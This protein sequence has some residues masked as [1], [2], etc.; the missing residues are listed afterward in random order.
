VLRDFWGVQQRGFSA[1]ASL[2]PLTHTPRT[3]EEF[4]L[5]KAQ[6]SQ[7]VTSADRASAGNM[8]EEALD[9]GLVFHV[10][11]KIPILSYLVPPKEVFA[12]VQIGAHQHKVT[13]DDVIFIEKLKNA[14]VNDKLLFPQVLLL[15]SRSA[16]VVGRPVVP[17]ACV[18][19]VVEQQTRDA[20]VIIFKKRRR[21]NSRKHA[22]HRQELTMLRILD[23]IGVE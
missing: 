7:V 1:S 4:E 6:F 10:M 22:G 21:K 18:I 14:D 11:G 5:A 23:I 2:E 15:G 12:V 8:S 20:K 16:T 17:R 9:N 3:D 13:T 19:A